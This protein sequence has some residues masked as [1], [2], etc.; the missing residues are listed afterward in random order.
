M[1][2]YT[3]YKAMHIA[4]SRY[5]FTI[6]VALMALLSAAC[7]TTASSIAAEAAVPVPSD[8]NDAQYAIATRDGRIGRIVVPVTINGQGTFHMMLDTGAT[9]SVLTSSALSRLGLDI[10]QAKSL[11][12]QGVSGRVTAPETP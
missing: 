4:L 2:Q 11:E 12:V 5:V 3:T 9:H 6:S 8:E 7:S 10:T 1:F